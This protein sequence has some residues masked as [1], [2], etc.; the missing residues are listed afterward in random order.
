MLPK[1]THSYQKNNQFFRV[2]DGIGKG[3]QGIHILPV[4][5]DGRTVLF[6]DMEGLGMMNGNNHESK[7]FAITL[8]LSSVMVYNNTGPLDLP[9]LQGLGTLA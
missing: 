9:A 8:L 5:V 1:L 4:Q 6:L 2:S 3:T 7:L